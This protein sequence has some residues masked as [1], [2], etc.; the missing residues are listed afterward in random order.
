MTNGKVR[1]LLTTFIK[2]NSRNYL[3]PLQNYYIIFNAKRVNNLFN[4]EHPILL[5]LITEQMCPIIACTLLTTLDTV[6]PR[7]KVKTA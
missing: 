5:I 6:A 7:F 1:F 2:F 3:T 4:W